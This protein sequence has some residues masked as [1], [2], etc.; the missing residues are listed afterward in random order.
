[1]VSAGKRVITI[2]V[3]FLFMDGNERRSG[4]AIRLEMGFEGICGG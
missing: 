4:G 1:M 2:E 3:S